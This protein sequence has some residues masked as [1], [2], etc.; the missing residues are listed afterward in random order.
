MFHEIFRIFE[1]NHQF[2][3][4]P[5]N[6]TITFYIFL[7]QN[8]IKIKKSVFEKLNENLQKRLF[9]KIKLFIRLG[10]N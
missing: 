3:Q 6:L 7:S 8:F 10:E 2:N 5:F 1:E 9:E 4:T